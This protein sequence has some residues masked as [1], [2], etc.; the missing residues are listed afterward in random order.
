MQSFRLAAVLAAL[1]SCVA[2]LDAI[3]AY[4]N[5]FFNK[6][7]SQFFMKGVSR[8]QNMLTIVQKYVKFGAGHSNVVIQ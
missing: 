6:D 4:G 2:S 5:K 7:G 1:A 3:E 8:S